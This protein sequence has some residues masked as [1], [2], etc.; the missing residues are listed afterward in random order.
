L[1]THSS[2]WIGCVPVV[3]VQQKSGHTICQLAWNIRKQAA[4]CLGA[5]AASNLRCERAMG[6]SAAA[7]QRQQLA[8]SLLCLTSKGQG[9]GCLRLLSREPHAPRT[10][11]PCP[12]AVAGSG[13]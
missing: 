3:M 10:W 7:A 9:W 11:A 4:S 2:C 12:A 1:L 6:K 13:W 5:A 8:G